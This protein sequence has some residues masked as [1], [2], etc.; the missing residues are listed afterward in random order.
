[1]SAGTRNTMRWIL[2]GIAN[3]LGLPA[4][5]AVRR[6]LGGRWGILLGYHRV[7]PPGEAPSHYRMG[8]DARLFEAQVRWIASRHRVVSIE[9]FLRWL[10][11]GRTPDED[12]VVLTFDDG[13][14]D[15]LTHAAPLLKEL[16]LPAIFYVTSAGVTERAA[17]WPEV[18]A[19]MIKLT[20][21]RSVTLDS[22][23]RS[24]GPGVIELPL[25]TA[26]ERVGACSKLIAELRTLSGQRITEAILRIAAG[27]D[28]DPV[29]AREST[30][31]ML[32]GDNLRALAADGFAIGSHS[33]THPYLPSEEPEAQRREIE[34]SRRVLEAT[35]RGPVLDFCYPGGGHDGRTRSIVRAAGYRS[36]VTWEAGVAGSA[37][38]PFALPRKGVGPALAAG[39]SGAFSPA[40]MEAEISGF[41]SDRFR[42]RNRRAS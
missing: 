1:L 8:M 34:D 30:P 10:S 9:E 16:G 42:R 18:L 35:I 17:Y 37:D 20:R 32:D 4:R 12:L 6:R 24:S 31:P 21:A 23:M 7:I 15:N 22:G 2:S 36:A 13:Y 25:A 33:A 5:H 39:L 3:G 11:S 19:A 29:K 41:I 26:A 28:V 27:L 38:D 40:M 14:R